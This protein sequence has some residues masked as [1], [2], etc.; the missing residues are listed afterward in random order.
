MV[1]ALTSE[2]DSPLARVSNRVLEMGMPV[3]EMPYVS[4]GYSVTILDLILI[5]LVLSKN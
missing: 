1:V 3:E 4:A 2:K 5:A